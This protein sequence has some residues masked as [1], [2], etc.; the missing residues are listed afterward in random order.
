MSTVR[1]LSYTTPL[2]GP[3]CRTNS[4]SIMVTRS[5]A[6]RSEEGFV[7]DHTPLTSRGVSTAGL[8]S[9]LAVK[10]RLRPVWNLSSTGDPVMVRVGGGTRG[11][12]C[13]QRCGCG[14]HSNSQE[15]SVRLK[16]S[17]YLR[18]DLQTKNFMLNVIVTPPSPPSLLNVK[19]HMIII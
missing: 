3:P 7:L 15:I 10:V 11:D 8:N 13:D 14:R 5:S 18:G 9:A 2:L 12:E 17:R 6:V 4:G 1:V 19:L 16:K